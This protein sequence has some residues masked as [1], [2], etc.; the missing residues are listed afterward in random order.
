MRLNCKLQ[1]T[2][3]VVVLAMAVTITLPTTIFAADY[4]KHW[5]N[6]AIEKWIQKEVLKGYED[7]NFRPNTA[8]TRGELAAVL[9]RVFGLNETIGATNYTDVLA[10]KWYAEDI[11]KVSAI[12]LMNDYADNT[13]KPDQLA[14]RE[15]AAY[16]I[17]QAYHITTQ[18]GTNTFKDA[19]QISDWA[20]EEVTALVAGGFLH[21]T[22]EGT[23][24]PKATITRAEVITM[25]DKITADLVNTEGT[26]SK[27]IEGNLVVNTTGVELKNMTITGN[28]YLAEGIG[29]GEV[30][31]KDVTIL[32]QLIVEG[33]S[34]HT[35]R[36]EGQ[37]K[38]SHVVVNKTSKTPVRL[39]FDEKVEV[40][41]DVILK[42]DAILQGPVAIQSVVA[43]GPAAVKIADAME[44][45]QVALNKPAV[46]ELVDG[47]KVA[48]I[49]VDKK[50]ESAMVMGS[51]TTTVVDKIIINA[52]DVVIGSGI[53]INK[54]NIII[55][56]HVTDVGYSDL[57]NTN[58][59]KDN[60]IKNDTDK[61]PDKTP[62]K[63]EGIVS[64]NK[65]E[66]KSL[67]V[68]KLNDDIVTANLSNNIININMVGNTLTVNDIR[69][70]NEQDQVAGITLLG[71]VK[72]NATLSIL[73]QS[74]TVT[75][76]DEY[77]Y[78]E[79][80]G[81]LG[82]NRYALEALIKEAGISDETYQNVVDNLGVVYDIL[83]DAIE[84]NDVH[85]ALIRANSILQSTDSVSIDRLQRNV[86]RYLEI[87]QM[88]PGMPRIQGLENLR[89]GI[90]YLSIQNIPVV[91]QQDGVANTYSINIEYR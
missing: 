72:G 20:K 52:N 57:N 62:E 88:F 42:S 64:G 54:D 60:N 26:Y 18:D 7:G 13:F 61:V 40:G 16:A 71:G 24:R 17:A 77:S 76:G 31:L 50:A 80:K 73:N 86:D 21:G 9:V 11:A 45:G 25:I 67:I 87:I 41:G 84:I 23:F 27:N 79:L 30:K 32:G 53:E 59:N 19:A 51:G 38:I 36:I 85:A 48:E 1:K 63:D 37:S 6:T 34:V 49:V 89:K 5:A 15:E 83:M 14:T 74:K 46:I 70:I 82:F 90:D 91:V 66:L 47:I 2:L 22:P 8:V 3:A 75:L 4:D 43:D 35:I 58:N 29:E 65:A 44:I 28:L 33:G 10:T 81:K 68:R 78:E 56:D 69:L 39:W 12:G 55:A